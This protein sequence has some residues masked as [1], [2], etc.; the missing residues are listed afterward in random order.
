MCDVK[1]YAS[2]YLNHVG[3]A[4]PQVR[5]DDFAIHQYI[6]LT[7][8]S[9]IFPPCK[10]IQ[11]SAI[12]IKKKQK[13]HIIGWPVHAYKLLTVYLQGNVLRCFTASCGTHDGIH[14][15]S[16]DPTATSHAML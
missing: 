7:Q 12:R 6:S 11:E 15:R 10:Y 8:S 16:Y 2:V 14:P 1:K 9:W 4:E 13:K 5:R 3:R